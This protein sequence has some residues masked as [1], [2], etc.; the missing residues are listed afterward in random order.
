M[1]PVRVLEYHL[2]RQDLYIIGRDAEAA[3]LGGV[4][5]LVKDKNEREEKLYRH[6]FTGLL[7]NWCLSLWWSGNVEAYH[8]M[9]RHQNLFPTKGDGGFDLP[10]CA[11]DIKTSMMTASSDPMRYH[12]WIRPEERHAGN[13]YGLGLVC[14]KDMAELRAA[15]EARVL[16]VGWITD[17]DLPDA[18]NDTDEEGHPRYAVKA[19]NLIP[20]TPLPFRKAA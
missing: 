2:S 7:G 6:Q 3:S 1:R 19:Y 16:L 17:D 9:R 20:F 10:G 18:P 14:A 11:I 8:M 13:T 12:L 4:S 15:G 5:R